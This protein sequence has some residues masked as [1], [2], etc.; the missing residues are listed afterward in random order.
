MALRLITSGIGLIVFFAAFFADELLFSLA[1]A[2][3]SLGMV[4][5]A[6]H[7]LKPGKLVTGVSMAV[8][9]LSFL[10]EL[11]V[12]HMQKNAAYS[13]G[14]GAIVAVCLIISIFVYLVLSVVLF[15][16]TD[17]KKIYS[18]MFMTF[19]IT[20][21]MTFIILLRL[22]F[23]RYAVI[24]AFLFSWITDS[25]A[26][27]AGSFLG[28]HKL[29]PKLS[30]KKTVEGAVGGIAA[31]VAGT[32]IY[33]AVLKY[34]FDLAVESNVIFVVSAAV[35]AALSEIGDL[36]ASV[37]KRQCDIKDFGWIF[38]GHGGFLDRFDSVV[39][40]APYVYMVFVLMQR[41]F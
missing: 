32:V 24:P 6:V 5:E 11:Y 23:G 10:T 19:Y 3:V 21:F 41:L 17:F 36:A 18:S 7:A 25:G 37:V 27:F 29:A 31:T 9:A 16:K 28:R 14:N 13:A 35:G 39:F 38:P 30:P 20:W 15:E 22:D 12:L 8:S 40:I 33:I 1:V 2:I 4:Y 34:C 26:Y